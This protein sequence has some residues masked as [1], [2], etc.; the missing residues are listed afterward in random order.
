MKKRKLPPGVFEPAL[1][2]SALMEVQIELH[3]QQQQL[4]LARK[5]LEDYC[6]ACIESGKALGDDPSVYRQ[7]QI[8]N[9]M[10]EEFQAL[11][12]ALEALRAHSSQH[13][14]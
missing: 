6:V 5:K 3:Y 4:K 8:F 11:Q 14:P 9:R 12:Q 10:L 2:S 1:N 13:V 7:S